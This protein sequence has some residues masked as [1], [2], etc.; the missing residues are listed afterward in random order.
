MKYCW[1]DS[2]ERLHDDYFDS[3]AEV[4]ESITS[5]YGDPN[6]SLETIKI[7]EVEF[8][9]PR[10]WSKSLIDPMDILERMDE[11][12]CEEIGFDDPVFELKDNST[13]GRVMAQDELDQV[14]AQWAEKYVACPSS[15]YAGMI[16]S[17]H[18]LE[19]VFKIHDMNNQEK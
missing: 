3:I 14:L 2:N 11:A 8:P 7:C 1:T 15:W 10:D 17:T 13:G 5:Y 16:I 12:I 9:N 18:K 4:I 19:E 6:N